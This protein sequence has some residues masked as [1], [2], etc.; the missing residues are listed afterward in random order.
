LT[1]GLVYDKLYIMTKKER[2][3]IAEYVKD[4]NA[5]R[6]AKAAGYSERSAS[7]IGYENINKPHIKAEIDRIYSERI[8]NTERIIQDNLDL[9]RSIMADPEAKETDKIKA[10]ELIGKYA[11]M[12]TE[13]IEHSGDVQII[14][15][16]PG[17]KD[18]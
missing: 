1:K 9:W 18:G 13:R 15:D 16:V 12:F 5:T 4:F 10:S 3:F 8:G 11:G 17:S 6:A 7:L 2:A 14:D